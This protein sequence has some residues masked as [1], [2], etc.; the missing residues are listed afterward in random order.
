MIM[1]QL[2]LIIEDRDRA[3]HLIRLAGYELLRHEVHPVPEGG[4]QADGS[5]TVEGCQLVLFDT[6]ENVS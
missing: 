1:Y 4:D 6:T 2:C 5:V 3:A